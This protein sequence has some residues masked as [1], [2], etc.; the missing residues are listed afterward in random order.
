MAEAEYQTI[1]QLF[2]QTCE[3][4][5]DRKVAMRK[6][7]F[8]I[9]Q[10]YSWKDYYD[11][12][13]YCSLGL[14]SLGFDKGHKIAI[15]GDND[16]EWVWAMFAA[17]V[18]G[19]VLAAGAYPDSNLDELKYII[20][21]SEATFVVA[22]DQ[23]QVDKMI[24]LKADLP[25]IKRVIHWDPKGLWNYDDPWLL[26][27]ED[28]LAQGRE[29]EDEHP[30]AFHQAVTSC[31]SEDLVALYYTSGTTGLPKGAMWTHRGLLAA[32]ANILDVIPPREGDDLFCLAPLSW[33][34]EI[35]M[36]LIPSMMSG[37]V[38][39]FPE[40]PETVPEDLREIGYQIGFIGIQAIQA[41]ISEIQV[42]ILGAGRLKR[43]TYDLFTPVGLKVNAMREQGKPIPFLW[44]FLYFC[45]YW[46]LYRPIQD[47]LGYKRARALLT[48][49][50][51]L[52]PDAFRYFRSIGIPLL[53][54]YGLTEFNPIASQRPG[55][56]SVESAGIASTGSEI[57]ISETGEILAR[58]P[59][60]T[61]GYYKNPEATAELIDEDG[62]LHTGDA[63]FFNEDGEL[64][65]IDRVKDLMKLNN[66]QVFSPMY[67]ENKLK[68]SPYIREAVSLGNDRDFVSALVS[69]DYVSLGKWAE[70]NQI[71]Y[72]TFTD[73][74]QK[75]EVYDLI[76]EEV[77]GR[78]NPDLPPESRIKKFTLLAKEL[79]ADDAELTRTRKLRRSFV[80]GRYKEYINALYGGQSEHTV[81]FTVKL[82]DGR[83]TE[84]KS[85][86]KIITVD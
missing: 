31:K 28:L 48:G 20:D 46:A 25:N 73:L 5:G 45:G 57:K 32:G 24:E 65:I 26:G 81:A 6:K 9:W 70:D 77:V 23:E 11:Q 44:R 18:S 61:I 15:I 27:F 12:V 78:V 55:M 13:K 75:D 10:S 62:W 64:V 56:V 76:K 43:W 52:A 72:T 1:S 19:G 41:Q 71:V 53:N 83:E 66:G 67:I 34:P 49:G 84:M 68:F 69:I 63:G 40:E 2:V 58:G 60:M 21:H 33:I 74:S 22:E 3:R 17:M 38:V 30:K 29:Y 85:R 16:L 35:L 36:N 80:A 82:Q 59:Q 8:G 39:N 86:V 7:L 4:F 47:S 50:S 14:R 42:K 51:A 37:A 54:A 79:D